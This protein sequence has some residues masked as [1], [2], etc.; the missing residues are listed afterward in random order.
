VLASSVPSLSEV[1]DSAPYHYLSSLLDLD[2]SS[3]AFHRPMS[4]S[5]FQDLSTEGQTDPVV[6]SS[7]QDALDHAF[8]VNGASLIDFSSKKCAGFETFWSGTVWKRVCLY[9][10]P[11]FQINSSHTF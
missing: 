5:S 7:L 8:A 3:W 10:H 2:L 4:L 6:S 11:L 1:G 9:A